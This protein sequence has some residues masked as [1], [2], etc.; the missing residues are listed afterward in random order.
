MGI[1]A[2]YL[3]SGLSTS[4]QNAVANAYVAGGGTA[5]NVLAPASGVSLTSQFHGADGKLGPGQQQTMYYSPYSSGSIPASSLSSQSVAPVSPINVGSQNG[6]NSFGS[7]GSNSLFINNAGLSGKMGTN[8][9]TY[10]PKTGIYTYSAPDQNPQDPNKDTSAEDLFAKYLGE[11]KANPPPSLADQYAQLEQQSGIQQKRER[12]QALSDQLNTVTA[13]AN[14]QALGLTGQ[15]RG[16]PEAILGGQQAQ[17]FKEAAIQAL[18]IQAQLSAATGDLNLAQD[19][20][21]QMFGL[22]SKDIQSQYEWRTNLINTAY[23]FA[24]KQ[25]QIKLDARKTAEN[26]AFSV[27]TNNLNYVQGLATSAFN[28]GSPNVGAKL[29]QLM[30]NPTSSTFL[31]DAAALAKQI[32]KTPSGGG[33]AAGAGTVTTQV[34]DGFTKLGTLTPSQQQAVKNDLY[35]MGFNSDT[36]PAW[37]KEYIESTLKSSLPPDRLGSEWQKYKS[38]ILGGGATPASS[39]TSTGGLDFN[40][41]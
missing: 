20:L 7:L 32:Q 4:Q 26:Q 8:N 17:I 14:A 11:A 30:Q 16:I 36:P 34:L 39:S 13:N 31:S 41:L 27:A 3:P 33:G 29:M 35:G 22:V 6:S 10:D 19:H 23:D 9:Y 38:G 1:S 21:Q 25:Q 2:L 18:P 24:S 15:G 5:G 28:N 37:F 40:S 12:V